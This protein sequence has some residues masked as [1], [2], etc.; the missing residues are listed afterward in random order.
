MA[1]WVSFL[2]DH[3][4]ERLPLIIVLLITVLTYKTYLEQLYV[5]RTPQIDGKIVWPNI[6]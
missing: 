4:A 6:V 3:L 5:M 1:G 2:S